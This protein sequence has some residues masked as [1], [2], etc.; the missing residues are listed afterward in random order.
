MQEAGGAQPG[1]V[2]DLHLAGHADGVVAGAE[3][4]Q[5]VRPGG[6]FVTDDLTLAL[7][8]EDEFFAD[9]LFDYSGGSPDSPSLLERAHAKVE[10][11]VSAF[12]CPLAEAVRHELAAYFAAEYAELGGLP[13]GAGL[14]SGE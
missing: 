8:R 1:G 9:G 11:L 2:D 7:L 4:G 5:Q 3:A 14:S 13:A 10:E 6:T 12:T